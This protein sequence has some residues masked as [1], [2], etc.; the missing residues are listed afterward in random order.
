MMMK[1]LVLNG[2][3]KARTENSFTRVYFDHIRALFPEH[4]FDMVPIAREA[5]V[6]AQRGK[7]FDTLCTLLRECDGIIWQVPVFTALIP[8]QVKQF[9]ELVFN[10]SYIRGLFSGKYCTVMTTSIQIFDNWAEY[11][12]QSISEQMGAICTET[13]S[14]QI[15]PMI[16]DDFRVALKGHLNRFLEAIQCGYRIPRRFAPVAHHTR[17]IGLPSAPANSATENSTGRIGVI[18]DFT[19]DTGNL[20]QMVDYFCSVTTAKVDV[21][22]L[23]ECDISGCT[24]CMNCLNSQRCVQ[25]DGFMEMHDRFVMS[26]DAVVYAGVVR[27]DYFSYRIK[28]F[29]DREFYLQHRT[30]YRGKPMGLIV[31]GPFYQLP[32]F[33]ES[34]SSI[35]NGRGGKLNAPVCDDG[36]SEK[37]LAGQLQWLA[38]TMA[39]KMTQAVPEPLGYYAATSSRT[40]RD[41]SWLTRFPFVAEYKSF[42]QE[43]RYASFPHKLKKIRYRMFKLQMMMLFRGFHKALKKYNEVRMKGMR[44]QLPS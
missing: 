31:S 38:T 44:R 28:H 22:N 24:S 6:L 21:L 29:M 41:F 11:Y 5:D 39:H 18:A 16:N 25:K 2:S 40:F 36:C 33:Q 26:A 37:E 10:D 12:L 9:V 27:E 20:K 35:W 3:P 8:S 19:D 15:Q 42:K 30:I 13:F 23:G 32:L 1:I 4:Q 43:G 17:Q 7:P 34:V 14:C